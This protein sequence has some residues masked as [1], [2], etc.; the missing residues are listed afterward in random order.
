MTVNRP[1]VIS[2]STQMKYLRVANTLQRKNL[3]VEPT[4]DSL[5]AL[6]AKYRLLGQTEPVVEENTTQFSVLIPLLEA[7][8]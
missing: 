1:L 6:L 5:S 8:C 2:V 7:E 4:I 3:R